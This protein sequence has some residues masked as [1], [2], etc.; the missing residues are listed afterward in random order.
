MSQPVFP[1]VGAPGTIQPRLEIRDLAKNPYQWS[2]FIRAYFN[3]Q[4]P[5]YK[6]E[7]STAP[8]WK[9]MGECLILVKL[10][11]LF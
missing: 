2:L 7:G 4:E 8:S 9:E 3:I 10:V 1:V 11:M 6:Y 5:D